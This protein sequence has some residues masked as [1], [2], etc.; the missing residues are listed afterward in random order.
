LLKAR[1]GRLIRIMVAG[2]IT[3]YADGGTL[4]DHARG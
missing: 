2:D 1:L 3:L 4:T